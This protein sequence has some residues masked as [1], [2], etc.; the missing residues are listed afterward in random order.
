MYYCNNCQQLPDDNFTIVL[1]TVTY[2]WCRWNIYE[3]CGRRTEDE[4][5][6]V[7]VPHLRYC[8]SFGI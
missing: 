8:K 1:P 5:S 4:I 7:T 2:D 6:T 3:E